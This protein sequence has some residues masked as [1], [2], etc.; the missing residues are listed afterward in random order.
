MNI[1]EHLELSLRDIQYVVENIFLPPKLPQNG[2]DAYIVSHEASMLAIVADA[3]QEF[4]TTIQTSDKIAING[5][6]KAIQRFRKIID[7]SGFLNEDMLR[8]AFCD[9]EENGTLPDPRKPERRCVVRSIFAD[10]NERRFLVASCESTECRF[11][12]NLRQRHRC[13]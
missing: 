2:D 12:H 11:S 8:E 13:V 3:L 9:L 7:G 5:A 10:R 6:A 1:E 4:S